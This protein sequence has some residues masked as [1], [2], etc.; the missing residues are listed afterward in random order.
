MKFDLLIKYNKSNLFLEK[1]CRKLGRETS[2]RTLFKKKNK[3]PYVMQKQLVCSLVLIYFGSPQLNIQ[4]KTEKKDFSI[5]D[6]E[7]SSILNF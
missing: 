6:P 1:S 3:N 7:F 5:N 2:P 4:E